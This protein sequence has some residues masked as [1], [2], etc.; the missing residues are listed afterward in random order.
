M[1]SYDTVKASSLDVGA[2]SFQ[3][4]RLHYTTGRSYTISGSGR[5]RRTGYR[6]GVMTDVGDLEISEWRALVR[7]LID[8]FGEQKLH[9]QL[10][11]WVTKSMLWLH[12]KE[13]RETEA[14]VLHAARI[15]DNPKWV[16]YEAFNQKYRPQLLD[17]K[18]DGH[19]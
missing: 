10:L 18:E 13:E 7:Q 3:E 6:T 19:G 16:D 9:N 5:D 11:T 14:L 2:L 12:T 8:R 4:L 1:G 17:P 15:F